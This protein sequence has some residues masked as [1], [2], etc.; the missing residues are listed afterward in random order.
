MPTIQLSEALQEALATAPSATPEY[1]TFEFVHPDWDPPIRIVHGWEEIE[2]RLE[3]P[4]ESGNGGEMVTFYPVPIDFIFEPTTP[5]EVPSFEFKFYDPSRLVLQK[6]LDGQDND[7]QQIQMYIR[8]YLQGRFDLQPENAALVPKYSVANVKISTG[9][10][11]IT[12]RCV[13]QDYLGRSAPFRTYNFA[14]F[15]GLRRR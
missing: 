13:F 3:D 10:S 2:A 14:E 1:Y 4:S 8:V 6:L 9:T 11:L 7:P 5:E 15:P 12:G